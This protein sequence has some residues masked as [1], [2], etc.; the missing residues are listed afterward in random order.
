MSKEILMVAEAVSNEKGVDRAVIFDAMEQALAMAT[1]KRYEE[2][3]NIRVSID[4]ESGNYESFRW[5]E[6]VADDVLAEL[7][8]QLTT[9]EAEECDAT[10]LHLPARIG[11]FRR[12]LERNS[13]GASSGALDTFRSK[14]HVAAPGWLRGRQ[15]EHCV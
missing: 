11:V 4:R 3:A 8:T 10:H 1:K 13:A 6:V 5:W 9:E 2:N 14:C 12:I 15:C 7:G